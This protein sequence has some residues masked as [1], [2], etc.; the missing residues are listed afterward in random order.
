M[1][2]KDKAWELYHK[3]RSLEGKWGDKVL[4]N[5]DAKQCALITVDEILSIYKQYPIDN[6]YY[7]YLEVK[8]EIEKL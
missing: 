4:Y 8:K 3:Y 1:E 7:Y 2:A 6:I 5:Y